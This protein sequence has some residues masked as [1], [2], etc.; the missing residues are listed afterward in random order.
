MENV[1]FQTPAGHTV[2]IKP[3]L[4]YPEKRRVQRVLLSAGR[5]DPETGEPSIDMGVQI[6]AQDTLLK[7]MIRRIQLTNGRV[8]EGTPGV[9]FNAL[10]EMDDPDIQTIY[11]KIDEL[12]AGLNI[13]PTPERGEKGSANS[14]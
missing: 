8:F 10:S 3:T 12:T 4:N 5:L 14:A 9:V 13:F 2:T 7:I 1:T 11:D 6:D